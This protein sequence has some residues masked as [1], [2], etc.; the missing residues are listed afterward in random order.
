MTDQQGYYAIIQYRP[1]PDR[2]EGLNVGV[3]VTRPAKGE[4]RVRLLEDLNVVL[5]RLGDR[6][7]HAALAP[8]LRRLGARLLALRDR[9]A[10]GLREFAAREPTTLTL[11][12]V[13]AVVVG[14]LGQTADRLFD[15]LVQRPMVRQTYELDLTTS[16]V[17]RDEPNLI[18]PMVL[19]PPPR[20]QRLDQGRTET[21]NPLRYLGA[22]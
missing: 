5:D 4:T 3:V 8:R 6:R 13:R 21:V 18:R 17:P 12:P 15:R 16:S 2:L 11:L 7:P 20:L 22:R 14:D 19:G 1:D 10:E 9:S